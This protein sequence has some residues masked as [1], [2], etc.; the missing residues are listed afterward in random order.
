MPTH[1]KIVPGQDKQ[2]TAGKRGRP[3]KLK[4]KPKPLPGCEK[5]GGF[6]KVAEAALAEVIQNDK[7]SNRD[8]A[9][10]WD[11][12]K[13]RSGACGRGNRNVVL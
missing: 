4:P 2:G 13:A 7:Y 9:A 12:T 3:Q 5:K 10:G 1:K 6:T 8:A 11:A